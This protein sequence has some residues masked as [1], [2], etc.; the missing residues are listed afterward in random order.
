MKYSKE[1]LIMQSETGHSN[2][3]RIAIEQN[4]KKCMERLA[5]QRRLYSI[6]KNIFALQF[7]LSMIMVFLGYLSVFYTNLIAYV[8]L[9]GVVAALILSTVL[10]E[11]IKK[12]KKKAAAVQEVLDCDLLRIKWNEA[13]A[14]MPDPEDIKIYSQKLLN[15]Q[16]EKADLVDWYKE[17]SNNLSYSVARVICQRYNLMWDLKLREAFSWAIIIVSYI[18]VF[19][20]V[21]L[22]LYQDLSIK[23]ILMSIV[24]PALSIIIF[25]IT[26]HNENK[27]S[28]E[29]MKR[30]KSSVDALWDGVVS[31]KFNDEELETRSRSLQNMIYLCRKG[32][33]LIPDWFAKI[34]NRKQQNTANRTVKQLAE[35]YEDAFRKREK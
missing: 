15:N 18:I 7:S 2:R 28:I 5:A 23:N 10:P 22:W 21:M 3:N 35:E 1:P 33:P 9:L 4:E 8:N 20:L 27:E 25:T 29:E 16:K 34:K 30:M 26:Q 6:A 17:I 14:L 32:N 13:L 12:Y 19:I 24:S 31:F 11:K